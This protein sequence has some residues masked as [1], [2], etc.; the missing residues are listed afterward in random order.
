MLWS[1]NEMIIFA[2]ISGEFYEYSKTASQSIADE[3]IFFRGGWVFNGYGL[4]KT[5]F[6]VVP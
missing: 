2:L 3:V 4:S 5:A 6:I 1:L